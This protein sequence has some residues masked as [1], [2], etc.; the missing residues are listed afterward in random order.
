MYPRLEGI[1]V[2]P[3]NDR[4]FFRSS[5]KLTMCFLY[6]FGQLADMPAHLEEERQSFARTRGTTPDPGRP[7][8]ANVGRP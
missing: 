8:Q 2:S 6:R 7:R 1:L 5:V 3:S 4:Y